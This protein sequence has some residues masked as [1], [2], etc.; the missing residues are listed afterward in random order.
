MATN[1][2]FEVHPSGASAGLQLTLES[3]NH[4]FYHTRQGDKMKLR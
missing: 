4:I 2:S 1:H 3:K